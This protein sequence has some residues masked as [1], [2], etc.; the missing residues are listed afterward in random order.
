[1]ILA[2]QDLIFTPRGLCSKQCT[3]LRDSLFMW[4]IHFRFDGVRVDST[5]TMRTTQDGGALVEAWTLLQEITASVRLWSPKKLLVAED[6]QRSSE[7]HAITGFDVQ[8]DTDL[9]DCLMEIGS[10]HG[11]EERDMDKIAQAI[12][13]PSYYPDAYSRVIFLENHDT[14]AEDREKRAPLWVSPTNADG[15]F[16]ALKRT[17]LLSAV[18]FTVPG[19][20]M[21]I[22]GQELFEILCPPWPEPPSITWSRR[23]RYSGILTFYRDLIH[24]RRNLSLTTK[25]LTGRHI[26][27]THN[28]NLDKVL[29][30]HRYKDTGPA[31]DVMVVMNFSNVA[32][33]QYQFGV[34][35]PG[36]WIVRLNSDAKCYSSLFDG[37]TSQRSYHAVPECYDGC[38][39]SII[40]ELP[41]YSVI[42]LSRDK[43]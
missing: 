24:L 36:E 12:H 29:G 13:V 34:P 15:N 17:T 2:M 10:Q 23:E 40:V 30:W 43:N 20:P 26:R 16:F 22:Q 35:R 8:W 5:V 42:I 14:V 27:V 33:K 3:G 41:R 11:D 25:G 28:N 32:F 18:V 1:M 9:F 39:F 19:I 7:I 21:M 4:L 6:L 37:M 31:D 38:F